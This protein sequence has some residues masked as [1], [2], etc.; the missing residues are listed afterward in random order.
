[1]YHKLYFNF[2]AKQYKYIFQFY[3][4]IMSYPHRKFLEL[5]DDDI[6]KNQYDPEQIEYSIVNDLLS[7]RILN[8]YQKLTP[9]ICAKYVIFG[10]NEEKYGDCGEDRWLSDIEILRSQPHITREELSAAHAFVEEEEEN[11]KNERELMNMEDRK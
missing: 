7:L 2:F 5:T 6:R 8:R 3:C 11:E 1:M 4:I 10:G 9:Y